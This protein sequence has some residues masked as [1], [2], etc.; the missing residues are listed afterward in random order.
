VYI[1]IFFLLIMYLSSCR[2][3]NL[4]I[5]II[6][7]LCWCVLVKRFLSLVF[8]T[9]YKQKEGMYPE[10]LEKLEQYFMLF[11][12]WKIQNNFVFSW[13]LVIHFVFVYSLH[14][15]CKRVREREKKNRNEW[16]LHAILNVLR[17]HEKNLISDYNLVIAY[18]I[19]Y[20]LEFFLSS[21]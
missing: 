12:T 20:L 16:R 4:I 7:T 10:A 2:H 18:I 1:I 15:K 5:I 19:D 17:I 11:Y 8:F 9:S 21:F 14:F 3:P 13:W 6:I